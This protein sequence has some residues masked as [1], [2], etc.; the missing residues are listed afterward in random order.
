MNRSFSRVASF[1][2]A[3]VLAAGCA[4]MQGLSTQAKPENANALAAPRSLAGAAVASAA[5]PD[6]DWWRSLNDPQLDRLMDEALAGSPTLKIAHART[7]KALAF[8]DVSKAA[9]YPQVN[10]D[11]EITRERF[12]ARGEA[13]PPLAGNWS[14]PHQLEATLSWE[15]DFWGKNRAAYE[16]ALGVA[17]ATEID[18]YAARLALS[19]SVAQTYVQLQRAFLQLD[20]AQA[21]L[22]ERAQIY[23]LTRDRNAAGLDTRLELKQ[24]ESE[25]PATREQRMQKFLQP[26]SLPVSNTHIRHRAPEKNPPRRAHWLRVRCLVP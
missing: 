11:A 15:L 9:L 22:K 16:S 4:S 18:A 19:T 20:V 7:R 14:T 25:V 26:P 6:K 3:A 2:M 5:W 17:R 1:L 8:A 13:A 10:A 23:A 24:A 21:T 12:S